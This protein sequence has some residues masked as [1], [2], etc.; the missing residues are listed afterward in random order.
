MSRTI[1]LTVPMPEDL[2]DLQLPK[3]LDERLHFLLDEQGR[4]GKLSAAEKR[5][6]DGLMKMASTLSIRRLG[7]QVKTAGR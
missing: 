6:V 3:A 7:A 1:E 2:S 4:K 5:E